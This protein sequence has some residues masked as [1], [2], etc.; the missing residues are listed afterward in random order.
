MDSGT[1]QALAASL[2]C[3]AL[4]LLCGEAGRAGIIGAV[5]WASSATLCMVAYYAVWYGWTQCK[6]RRR[7]HRPEDVVLDSP[8]GEGLQSGEEVQA[9]VVVY[10]ELTVESVWVYVY[11]WGLLL[12]VCLYSLCGLA[13]SASCWWA[14]G[15]LTLVLDEV[16]M[17][18]YAKVWVLGIGACTLG[19]I[20]AVWY[21][22][23]TED[24]AFGPFFMGALLPVATPFIFFTLRA[25]SFAVRDV[26]R[27]CELAAPFMVVLAVC[28]LMGTMKAGSERRRGANNGTYLETAAPFDQHLAVS[29]NASYLTNAT[30]PAPFDQNLAVSLNGSYLTNASLELPLRAYSTAVPNP[31]LARQRTLAYAAFCVSPLLGLCS[32]WCLVWSVLNRRCTE[33]MAAFLLL[34]AIRFGL[35]HEYGGL[36]IASSGLAALGF[37]LVLFMRR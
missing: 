12:F 37:C 18:G 13:P 35:T 34:L 16:I 10:P 4:L 25:T 21:G 20:T 11:G 33:F 17:A 5:R 26:T 32:L 31:E 2:V 22:E 30:L 9:R 3:N 24:D 19:S 6:R 7:Y 29:L 27:L 14:L 8:R 1:P 36:T 28:T 23:R 15:M